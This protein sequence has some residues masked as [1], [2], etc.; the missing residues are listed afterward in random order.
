METSIQFADAD[1]HP[2]QLHPSS[3]GGVE[4]EEAEDEDAGLRDER[5]FKRSQAFSLG[6]IFVLAY[7]SIGVIYGDI[8]TSPLYVF[9]STFTVAPSHADLLGA[10]SL[11]LWSIT[12]M[13]TI[14]YV[15]VILHADNDGEGG[16]FSTYSLL[17]KYANI[18]NRDPREATLVRM[19]RH[20][21]EDLGRSTRGIRS[22][23]EKS[24]FFR[25]LLQVIGVL[26]V[27]MVMADGVLTPAQ[28]VLG[29]V[30]GLNVVKP[31][32]EKSTI[33]GV[34]CAIL[35]LLFVVQPFG[36]TKLTVVFSPIVIVWLALNAGFGIY[37]LSNYDYKILKAF[38][39][40][41]AFDYL[42]RNKYHGWRSLGGI[43]LAFTGVEA[44]FADIGA[45]S[46]RAV[47]ISWLGYAYPCLLLA[48]SGQA[49]YISVHPAAYA[50]PF[51][52]CVPHGWLIFS[53]VVAI[54]AA[55]V[56]S[57]AM[58][59][60]TFQLLS[61]IMKLSYFPQ[62]KVIHT[63]TT[64]H[65]QLYIPSI[66]WLLMIGTVLVASIYNN[67]TSLGNAYGVCVMFVTFFDTCMVT[68]V[69]I[70]VWQIKPYFVLL[71]WL[72]IAC[73]DGAYLSS[74][75]IKV[76]DG[77]WFTILLACLLGSIFILWRFGKEQ[78]WSAEASDR[79]PTTHFVKTL[80]DGRLTL[81]EKYDSKPIGTMEG[82]GIF[83]DKAGETTPIVFSQFIRKLVTVPEVIV[84]FHLRP[85]EVPF[86]E[87]ENRYSVSRLA[88]P[89]CYRLVV[90][91]GYMDEVITPDL[92]SLIYDKI[93]NHIIS[94]ALDC[95]G[96]AEK[97]SSAPDAATTSID[98]KIP[99]LMTTATPGTC[100]PH[101]RTSTSTTSSRLEKLERAFNRE[102]LYI[103]GK[104]QM[105]VKPGSSLIRM[106][107]LEAFFFLREN[108]R[109]KIASLS[110]SMDKVIEVGFV[111]D[112]SIAVYLTSSSPS[113]RLKNASL[114]ALPRLESA[115]GTASQPVAIDSQLYQSQP[116]ALSPPP[117]YTHTFESRLRESQPEDAIVAP[118]EGSEQATL[119]PSS[120][121]ADNAR[122]LWGRD[123]D[124]YN[125]EGVDELTDEAAFIKEWRKHGPLG[126]L[127][128]I[129]NYIYTP[130]QYN[131]FEKAQRTAY[132]ARLLYD[133]VVHDA[134]DEAPE[135]HL[136]INL[137]AALLKANEY[138]AKLN[139]SPAYYAATILH[140]RYKHYCDQAWAE[141]PD[142]LALNNLNFQALW[143]DY[144]SLP[145]PRPCYT[146]A[147][148]KPS[149]I[150]DAIDGI[151][152]PTRGNT[153]ED[154]YEQW[155][156]EPIVGKGT[157]PIQYWFGLRDQYPNL[158]KMALT[159]LSIPA[160]SCEC[161]RV[162]S[163][164]G[165]LLEPRRRCISPELLAALHSVRRWRRAG[166]GGG[167]NDDMGQSKLTDEQMDV[168]YELS[169]WVGED[170]DLDTWDDG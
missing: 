9:S 48:Y 56:A 167:D 94:R 77:A 10:L 86:V 105:K 137:R 128:D 93:H 66:N 166:F 145:L 146:R 49:A 139:D 120:E 5:D 124:L 30:Q 58:I 103:I 118:A 28:S 109:A 3:I 54:A 140:P 15:L 119:A 45:F 104:E 6:Q 34:T 24:K 101:S 107:F 142:W 150:D 44:L 135:D 136:P 82:F 168:L 1:A 14:K 36:I 83:F 130:Q 70:L 117:P 153:E 40:Y 47:Q 149:N 96:E 143:A 71:P 114:I 53:L 161:E 151:I 111:K 125:N 79:F 108:S 75:L 46:R 115:R 55:I 8:G 87:P 138:Y 91:H 84:F 134:H 19:Q 106:M 65:G 162:F 85:L 50:N 51:Y 88:V 26:S 169:K 163:E 131:L 12:L 27:S 20:K 74:A 90:R 61:Q 132:Q 18:A 42:I 11:V 170:D 7:Q 102:V 67:T 37:N 159:I 31:D 80:P 72:I 43:L 25:G 22:A 63:S 144:K 35:I 147:P 60:A 141:K 23:I 2:I 52:N 155:K 157:D 33:I 81:T 122:L 78:Q 129:V 148:K 95:G 4:L 165:D 16:T 123:A 110:V 154:E 41:Y 73:L 100:T 76:P 156:R 39:P 68:L 152:D 69:A 64:Y 127:L 99:I 21:T 158:S 38:N 164:L 121:A 13:V 97:E 98:T 59:T 89:H 126:V 32:I 116:S 57:Q 92:A 113:C 29:A 17:S 112:V 133:C 62:I 160:S